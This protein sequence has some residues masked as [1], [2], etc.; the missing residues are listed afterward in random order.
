MVFLFLAST[1]QCGGSRSF[2]PDPDPDFSIRI[3][4][5]NKHS[6]FLSLK[7]C[8]FSLFLELKL[9]KEGTHML[10]NKLSVV[11]SKYL[12]KKDTRIRIRIWIIKPGSG[13]WK[14]PG[15]TQIRIRHAGTNH[16]PAIFFSLH[17]AGGG[18]HW[19]SF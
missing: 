4:V 15:S 12:T 3:R 2:F 16:H 10:K 18:L 7:T 1:N 17:N 14:K 19:W 8:L 13:S 9:R 5:K 6:I 11:Q